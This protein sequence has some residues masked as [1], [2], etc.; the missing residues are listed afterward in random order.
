[1]T[2]QQLRFAPVPPWQ[3]A[4]QVQQSSPLKH[5]WLTRP[6]ALTAGLRQLGQVTLQVAREYADRLQANESWMI[7]CPADTKVWVREVMMSINGTPSVIAR[8]FCL[9][10][11]S[12]LRWKEIRGLGERPLAD[13]LYQNPAIRRDPFYICQLE[14][15]QPLYQTVNQQLHAQTPS[16]ET[17]Y[18]RCSTF[19]YEDSPLLVA[20]C[21]LPKF[22][23]L[24]RLLT[25]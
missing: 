1:M 18:A 12:Q 21:F 22:W 19:W 10:P 5:Y 3:M 17:L 14:E 20:E 7:Q 6:G 2:D 25:P 24:A 11:D 15:N 16:A 23:S 9:L 13:L 4:L 8:S